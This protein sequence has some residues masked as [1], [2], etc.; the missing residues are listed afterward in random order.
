MP[1]NGLQVVVDFHTPAGGSAADGVSPLAQCR[2]GPASR[3][4][5]G[6]GKGGQIAG[7]ALDLFNRTAHGDAYD[8]WSAVNAE[9]NCGD[10]TVFR[11][12]EEAEELNG[13]FRLESPRL[14]GRAAS[15]CSERSG[16]NEGGLNDQGLSFFLPNMTWL[17]PPGWVHAMIVSDA[18]FLLILEDFGFSE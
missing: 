2:A 15:F 10:H 13:Y 16:Y 4:P 6:F 3:F 8:G 5:Q 12:L 18:D 14:L 11:M 7:D 17:Q 9:T 1:K